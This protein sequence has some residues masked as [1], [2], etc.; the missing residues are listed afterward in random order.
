MCRHLAYVGRAQ[1]LHDLLVAPEFGLHRQAW[2]PRMQKHG[3]VNADGFGIGWWAGDPR[4]PVTYRRD[5]PMWG[6]PSLPSITTATASGA[7]IAA[8]RSATEGTAPGVESA[9]PFGDGRYLFSHNGRIEDWPDG[10][11]ELVADVAPTE[12]LHL[13]AR[14]DSALLWLMVQ[15]ALARGLAAGQA[16]ATVALAAGRCSAGRYNLLLHDG[17]Q[18]VATAAGDTLFFLQDA[19]GITVA[20]E[21]SHASDE[22]RP[23]ADGS[24]VV[25]TSSTI[26]VQPLERLA[27]DE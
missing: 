14:T 8:V 13:V 23:V 11:D 1:T 3:T 19:D 27:I 9:A 25:A 24:V 6:D 20:S 10:V 15:R 26:D 22:W 2:Q 18:I 12:L 21:P 16:L 17:E 4:R 5:T 7:V